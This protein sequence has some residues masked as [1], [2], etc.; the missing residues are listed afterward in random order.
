LKESGRERRDNK[1]ID[2][3]VITTPNGLPK[4]GRLVRSK[5]A[6]AHVKA[7]DVGLVIDSISLDRTCG[8][9]S[10]ES[11]DF[12]VCAVF[13]GQSVWMSS[14]LVEEIEG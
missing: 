6:W 4:K 7:G 2:K 10:I 3:I 9:D 14:D 5:S 12:K 13:R 8:E 1:L 11:P